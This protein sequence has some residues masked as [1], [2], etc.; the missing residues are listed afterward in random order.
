[1]IYLHWLVVLE[2]SLIALWF[3]SCVSRLHGTISQ[4]PGL[5]SVSGQPR[6]GSEYDIHRP[7]D[8]NHQDSDGETAESCGFNSFG[9]Y[10]IVVCTQT[11]SSPSG[12]FENR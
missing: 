5:P 12:K 2:A 10:V 7:L 4:G 6:H 9:R 1:V 11:S 3:L 8:Y